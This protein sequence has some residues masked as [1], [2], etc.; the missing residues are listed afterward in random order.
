MKTTELKVQLPEDEVHFLESYAR[1][2]AISVAELLTRYAR[3]LH[4]RASHPANIK[5]TGTI[6]ADID[7]TEE[8][9]QHVERKH[10]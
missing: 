10:R 8:Y 7:A 3:R 1:Q 4:P 5:L 9:L 6:P 2:H